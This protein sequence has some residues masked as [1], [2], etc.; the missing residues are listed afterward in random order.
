M[1]RNDEAR[2]HMDKALQLDPFSFVVRWRSS[3]IYYD[4]EQFDKALADIKVCLDL[5]KE[6]LWAINLEFD[7]NLALKTWTDSTL[8]ARELLRF[9][10]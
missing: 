8:F 2:K 4:Q 6:H 5:N 7:I 10:K 3:R 9:V 1:G